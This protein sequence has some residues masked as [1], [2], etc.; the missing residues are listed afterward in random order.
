MKPLRRQLKETLGGRSGV[1]Y[2]DSTLI[3][4]AGLAIFFGVVF[5]MEADSVRA[6]FDLKVA[7]GCFALAALCVL[8]ASNRVLALS[9]AVMVPA[10]LAGFNAGLAGNRKVLAFCFVSLAVGLLI[11]IVGTLAKSLWRSSRRRGD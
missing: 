3:V 4:I 11:L 8:L 1:W 10:A 6:P 5:G 9:C 7:I 2:R